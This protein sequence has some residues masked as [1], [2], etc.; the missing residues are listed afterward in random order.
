MKIFTI[1]TTARD[2][3][4]D[5][6]GNDGISPEYITHDELKGFDSKE[7]AFEAAVKSAEEEMEELNEDCDEGI[8]FG[9]PEDN[10]YQSSDE[11][12]VCYYSEDITYIVTRRTIREVILQG[13]TK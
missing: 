10:R 8:S 4:M 11:V 3:Y 2:A 1:I 9:I 13:E 12:C 6:E 5:D 7:K